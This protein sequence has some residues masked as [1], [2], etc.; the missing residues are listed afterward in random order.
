MENLLGLRM[1][2]CV[3]GVWK[4]FDKSLSV[5]SKT[6]DEKIYAKIFFITIFVNALNPMLSEITQVEHYTVKFSDQNR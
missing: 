4:K 3:F 1:D 6:N 5:S 2:R